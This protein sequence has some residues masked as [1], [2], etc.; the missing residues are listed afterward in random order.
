M[1]QLFGPGRL[2]AQVRVA[3]VGAGGQ[4]RVVADILSQLHQD[5]LKL[6]FFDDRWRT[7]ILNDIGVLCCPVS[8][9]PRAEKTDAA[10]VAIGDNRTRRSLHLRLEESGMYC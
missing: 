10:F 1:E 8:E 7:L 9:I 3:V 2:E 5:S 4:R 6:N